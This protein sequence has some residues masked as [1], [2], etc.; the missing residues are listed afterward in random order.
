MQRRDFLKAVAAGT[1]LTA[2]PPGAIPG[3]QDQPAKPTGSET[4]KWNILVVVSDTTRTAFLGPYGNTWIKTPTLDQLAKESAL[5]E[6]A[7]PECLPTIP[8]RRTLHSGRRAF[9]FRD[10]KPIPWDNVVQ[11][12]WQPMD[13]GQDVVAEA[14]ARAGYHNGFISDVPHYFVPGNNFTR[15]FHQWDFV[16]GNAEDRYRATAAVDVKKLQVR[17]G[18]PLPRAAQHV[19]NLGGFAPDEMAFAT[20]RTFRSA[21]QFLEE[22][23]SNPK[24][25]YLYVDT[26]HPHETWEAPAKYYHLYRD[27]KYT[28]RTYLQ[29]PY[30]TLF[31]HPE[32]EP[33]LVDVKAHYAG[34][35][36]MMDH[37]LG[38]L[39]AKLRELG[40]DRD[41]L[42][43]YL[44]DHGTNFGDNLEKALGKPSGCLYPGTMDV[45]LLVRHPEGKGAG[46]RFRE[47]VSSLD[48]PATVCAVAS[49]APKEGV[50]G[51]NLLPLLEG[52]TFPK[53][54]YLTCRYSNCVWYTDDKN[55]YF[56][57]VHGDNARLFDL[58]AD[59]PFEQTIAKKAPERGKRAW[60]RILED[61]GGKLPIYPLRDG[62]KV[63]APFI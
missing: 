22:N 44:S 31:Q 28:G 11:P 12:G 45:P 48:V 51:R 7:H 39:L 57:D 37:W 32:V 18:S 41:T 33:A 5:F 9:P 53:R 62:D 24:P 6:R 59:K 58:E 29:L 26:F 47:F 10:Y 15:G 3:E 54:E 27:P 46:K 8:T 36:T 4:R 2:L 63:K 19:A 49:T 25:F 52:G 40:K 35:V 23:R 16:R 61:A 13:S 1:T 56:S 55:W 14:L 21:M 50:E 20:P 17:Y 60:Q 38:Q 34:L 43:I 30:S 42:V